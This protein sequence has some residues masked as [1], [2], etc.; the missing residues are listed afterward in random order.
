MAVIA[1]IFWL[2]ALERVEHS[3]SG[4]VWSKNT[5]RLLWKRYCGK[6]EVW[7]RNETMNVWWRVR[8]LSRMEVN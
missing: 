8:V 4:T 1:E 5:S 2:K 7:G 6:R 3:K